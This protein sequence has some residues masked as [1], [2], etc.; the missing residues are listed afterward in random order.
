MCHRGTV[1]RMLGSWENTTLIPFQAK[2]P[3]HGEKQL[4]DNLPLQLKDPL[5]AHLSLAKEP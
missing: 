4:D 5:G 3:V 2:K 1:P